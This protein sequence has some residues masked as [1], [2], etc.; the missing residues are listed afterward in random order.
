MLYDLEP[1]R[2]I[3]GGPWYSGKKFDSEFV[4]VLNEQCFR[5]LVDKKEKAK[6]KHQKKE[7]QFVSNFFQDFSSFLKLFLRFFEFFQSFFK[8][9]R[10]FSNFFLVFSIYF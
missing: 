7:G 2:S 3:T 5:Y 6:L 9:F 8:I 10:V 4:E 1:D